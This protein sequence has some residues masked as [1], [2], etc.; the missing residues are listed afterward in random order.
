MNNTKDTLKLQLF[1]NEYHVK[2]TVENIIV[3]EQKD[4]DKPKEFIESPVFVS[5]IVPILIIGI[6][7]LIS[8]YFLGRK[9]KTEIKRIEEEI[10][11]M[12]SSFQPIVLSTIQKT[13]EY[14]LKDKVNALK[15]IVDYRNN[16]YTLEP[17]YISGISVCE[18]D[19]D[20]Y[21][22]VY[23]KINRHFID[24]FRRIEIEKGYFFPDEII[25][26]IHSIQTVLNEI[27]NIQE[28]EYS[29]QIREIPEEAKDKLINLKDKFELVISQ[30]RKDLHLDDKFIHE[31]IQ[32]YKTT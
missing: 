18:D 9:D 7:I 12:K 27:Y 26:N 1:S 8:K 19:H 16:L 25:A 23:E 21:R 32:K 5:L 28:R 10:K 30:I 14:I 13:Q 15:E 24:I 6:N 2:E 17:F 3:I 20:Y 4:K 22:T 29:L 11:Q 31:F